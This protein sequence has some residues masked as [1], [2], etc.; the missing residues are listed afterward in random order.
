MNIARSKDGTPI[1]YDQFG[2]GP[3]LLLV[4]GAMATRTDATKTAQNLGQ[5]FTVFAYDR[6]G[7]GQSGD[8]APS[9]CH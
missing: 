8:T 9:L 4:N 6:R 3:A 1:A 5:H 2:E 7:R